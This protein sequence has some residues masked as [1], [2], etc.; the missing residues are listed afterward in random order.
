MDYELCPFHLSR[1]RDY[2]ANMYVY[3][4]VCVCVYIH[5]RWKKRF[6]PYLLI[7]VTYLNAFEIPGQCV[8]PGLPETGAGTPGEINPPSFV[9]IRLRDTELWP[10]NL[11]GSVS[12]PPKVYI[13]I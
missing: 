11:W 3:I 1:Q 8:P 13:Y 7:R 10:K 12:F 5:G 2:I 9:Q 4:C 6:P